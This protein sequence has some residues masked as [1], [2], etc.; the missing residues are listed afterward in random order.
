MIRLPQL[1]P[2]SRSLRAVSVFA[3]TLFASLLCLNVRAA[4]QQL[5][6]TPDHLRFGKV[7]L[8][9]TEIQSV[10]LTNT[11][12]TSV[13][14][15]AANLGGTEFSLTTL[16][17][18]L[19]LSVGQSAALNV[20]FSPTAIGWTGGR[21]TFT[22]NA[23]NPTLQFALAGTGAS[24]EAVTPNPAN[25]SFGQVAV[26]SSS[27]LPVVLTNKTTR[28]VVLSGFL[29]SGGGFSVS[30]PTVPLKL[31]PGRS[32]T[33]NVTYAPR[34]VGITGG[35]VYVVGP[36]LN[37]P[38]TGTGTTVG[39]LTIN[40]AAL[41][42]GSVTVGA[43]GTQAITMSATGGSVTVSSV[44]S[45]GSQFRVQG[46]SLPLTLSAGQSAQ[47]N[48]AFSPQS[49]GSASATL[50]FVSNATNSKTSES[51]SGTGAAPYVTLS[52]NPSTS[53]VAG[54]NVYRR[55]PTSSSYT[56][57]N[58][59]PDPVTSFSDTTVALGQ[60][61]DYVTTAVSASGQESAFSNQVEIVVP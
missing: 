2:Q 53:Q 47:F 52:W 45:S 20:S 15:T 8:G 12:P 6:C 17:L 4:A 49:T 43:M 32:V 48:V 24:S 10:L 25:I 39:Q 56:K 37:I 23:T 27:K 41:N 11:G 35:S 42:F 3:F 5:T 30:G 16:S 14:V 54:Y 38:F 61:Y 22:S 55:I 21:I 13:T 26:G 58:S 9:Q 59:S 1:K 18:P 28:W 60:T 46:T 34:N 33:L 50:S 57:L 19:T 31:A 7:T 36:A 40:P 51:V 29:E 44:A